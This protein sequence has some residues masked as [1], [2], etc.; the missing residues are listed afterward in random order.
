MTVRAIS[1]S[2]PTPPGALLDESASPHGTPLPLSGW[3]L[4]RRVQPNGRA[5]IEIADETDD[6]IGLITSTDLPILSVDAAWRGRA[7]L[8]D[9]ARQWWALAI[10]HAPATDDEPAVTFTRRLGARGNA[11]RTVVRPSR[12]QGLW[13]AAAPGVHTTVSVRQGPEH[14]IR[15]LAPVPRF[16]RHA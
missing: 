2:Y 5:V 13:I 11:R 6:L 10:G 1:M 16:D 8:A 12:L 3:R 9:G 4:R 14:R 7:R 15:R